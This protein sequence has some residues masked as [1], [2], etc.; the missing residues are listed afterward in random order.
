M[1]QKCFDSLKIHVLYGTAICQVLHLEPV[2][3][4]ISLKTIFSFFLFCPSHWQAPG[5]FL[6]CGDELRKQLLMPF[7]TMNLAKLLKNRKL[8]GT[9]S[10]LLVVKLVLEDLD[11][12]TD[13][14]PKD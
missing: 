9:V 10:L 2:V 7:V 14:V 4:E 1:K 5:T 13:L 8:C 12:G 3:G 11:F 6:H